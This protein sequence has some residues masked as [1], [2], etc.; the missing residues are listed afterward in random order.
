MTN[1]NTKSSYEKATSVYKLSNNNYNEGSAFFP[2]SLLTPYM[3]LS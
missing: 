3:V 1:N 2:K